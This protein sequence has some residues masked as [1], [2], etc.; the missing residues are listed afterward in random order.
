MGY[1]T[2]FEGSFT[3]DRQLEPGHQNYLAQFANTRRMQRNAS[4]TE[5]RADP[6]RVNVGLPVGT[7]GA[8]FVG[9]NGFGGQDHGADVTDN[10]R[11]PTGQPGLWCQWVPSDD[12]MA[13]G[14]DG[15][16]KFY[17]YTEWL[18]YLIDNFLEPWGYTLTGKVTWQGEES[19][20]CGTIH[21]QDNQ[22]QALNDVVSSPEP[23]WG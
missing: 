11:A 23:D 3:L 15:G 19:G 9:E 12:G 5:E 13:I 18:A 16:E 7:D 17:Y 10:N 20:D 14:W 22:I 4:R 1:T 2:D 6:V 21:V 8:Y